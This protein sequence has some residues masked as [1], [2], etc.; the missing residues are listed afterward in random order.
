MCYSKVIHLQ[1]QA[2][3]TC[4][5]KRLKL[6][7]KLSIIKYSQKRNI[8]RTI[9]KYNMHVPFE[10]IPLLMLSVRYIDLTATDTSFFD[11]QVLRL[12]CV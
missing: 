12:C 4:Q 7:L 8:S 9:Y 5:R 3:T 11:E 2:E 1:Q 6:Q 10:I